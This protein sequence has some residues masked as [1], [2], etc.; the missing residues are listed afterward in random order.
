MNQ[1][2][3][4]T[5]DSEGNLIDGG[6]FFVGLT[7]YGVQN[8]PEGMEGC[9]MFRIEYG[10]VNESQATEGTMWLPPTVNVEKVEDFLQSLFQDWDEQEFRQNNPDSGFLPQR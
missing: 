7:E 9:R 2:S 1:F 3:Y 10:G 5:F 4:K 8:W 6:K